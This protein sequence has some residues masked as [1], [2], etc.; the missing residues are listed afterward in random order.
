MKQR[1]AAVAAALI[2]F[3]SLASAGGILAL[4]NPAKDRIVLWN[5]GTHKIVRVLKA[6]KQE[7]SVSDICAVPEKK[8]ALVFHRAGF[9]RDAAWLEIMNEKGGKTATIRVSQSP[10][11]AIP[12]GENTVLV[13]HTFLSARDGFFHAEV[14]NLKTEKQIREFQ[15]PGIPTNVVRWKKRRYIVCEDVTGHQS[16]I[17]LKATG[18][19]P[20]ILLKNKAVTSNIISVDGRLFCAVN[21][22]GEPEYRDSVYEIFP[23]KDRVKLLAK[24]AKWPFAAGNIGN[25]IL[26]LHTNH[27]IRGNSSGVSLVSVKTGK[28]RT[29]PTAPGPEAALL[30]GKKI[31]I[32]CVCSE[33]ITEINLKT[34]KSRNYKLSGA[35]TG[36]RD[37][38]LF[39]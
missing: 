38:V 7:A 32:A 26:I 25:N 31:Y 15:L 1:V 23:E 11:L 8:L 27:M 35:D 4:L 37:I 29:Y 24:T 19:Y 39:H 17:L 6:C 30:M 12:Y 3:A 33:I 20:D 21:H 36:F 34:G 13:N 2:F 14:V 22:N 18:P 10:F 9:N 16:G 28:I 5:S